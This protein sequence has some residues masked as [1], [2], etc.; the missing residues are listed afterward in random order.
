MVQG[1]LQVLLRQEVFESDMIHNF[2]STP[3]K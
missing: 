1:C 3:L 2:V